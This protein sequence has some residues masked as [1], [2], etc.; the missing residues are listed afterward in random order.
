MSMRTRILAGLALM[1]VARSLNLRS[2]PRWL[3]RGLPSQP[4]AVAD[5]KPVNQS[6]DV[7]AQ[8]VP[9]DVADLGADAEIVSCDLVAVAPPVVLGL[10]GA[11]G[12]AELVIERIGAPEGHEKPVVG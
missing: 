10:V 12:L 4:S 5:A 7:G 8:P 11:V 2:V 1:P 9:A 3:R 6:G